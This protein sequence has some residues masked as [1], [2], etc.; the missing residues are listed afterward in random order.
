MS[1]PSDARVDIVHPLVQDYLAQLH[2]EDDPLVEAL[3]RQARDTGF[4]LI[5]RD[6]GRTLE[7][8]AL[9]IGARR[10]LELGSGFGY[11]AY[12]L[13]R[14]VG[15]GGQVLCTEKDAWELEHHE[16]LWAG[17]PLKP[18]VSYRL[19]SALETLEQLDGP[20]DLVLID[21]DKASYLAAYEAAVPKVR[22]GGLICVD[23]VLWGGKIGAGAQD[24]STQALRTFNERVA[25]DDRVQ[26]VFL[27]VGDG[28][29]VAR[30]R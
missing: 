15:E 28:L 8:L 12:F 21:L 3:E 4:P 17:H 9:S 20:F 6:S 27:S 7:V 16:R 22:A 23:N 29:A 11:S 30:V 5:G 14:A 1:H 26:A 25:A 10:V 18:R 13:A 19:G 2:A 24:P